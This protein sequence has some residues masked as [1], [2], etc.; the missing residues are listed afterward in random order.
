MANSKRKGSQIVH[1]AENARKDPIKDAI[2]RSRC[3]PD[4]EQEGRDA[5]FF[6]FGGRFLDRWCSSSLG[7]FFLR[8]L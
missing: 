5:F 4:R 3:S 8:H 2:M 7:V 6:D 1:P